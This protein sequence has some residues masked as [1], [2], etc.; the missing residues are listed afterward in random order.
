MIVSP[1]RAGTRRESLD[2]GGVG[3]RGFR[4]GIIVATR[5]EPQAAYR[6]NKGNFSRESRRVLRHFDTL[7]CELDC[8][9]GRQP[10][11]VMT[12]HEKPVHPPEAGSLAS[13]TSSL[14]AASSALA[15]PK[16]TVQ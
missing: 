13:D 15:S 3:E 9:S 16:A 4:A 14:A 2:A 8:D 11:G 1:A 12:V 10:C 7:E 5:A 6:R